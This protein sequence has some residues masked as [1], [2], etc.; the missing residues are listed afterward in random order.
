MT[1]YHMIKNRF[2]QRKCKTPS[3]MIQLNTLSAIKIW[4]INGVAIKKWIS[5]QREHVGYIS[6]CK[7][8]E[9][10]D[11]K[12][13]NGRSETETNMSN[14]KDTEGKI[15]NDAIGRETAGEKMMNYKE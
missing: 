2:K 5:T 3:P 12:V 1:K 11:K 13:D 6:I 10:E 4:I 7:Y 8:C 15:N 14:R 9:T